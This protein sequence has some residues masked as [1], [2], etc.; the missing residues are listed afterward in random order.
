MALR[1]TSSGMFEARKGFRRINAYRQLPLL[2][3]ALAGHRGKSPVDAMEDAVQG[4]S[5]IPVPGNFYTDQDIPAQVASELSFWA[6]RK[7]GIRVSRL[8]TN[9]EL[10]EGFC[11]LPAQF[12][13]IL[14]SDRPKISNL[15]KL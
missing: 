10:Q 6:C 15:L 9:R 1:S 11:R 7:T 5:R 3:Q 14:D 2:E 13:R 8:R 12:G 4:S